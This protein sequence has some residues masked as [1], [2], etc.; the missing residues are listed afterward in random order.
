MAGHGVLPKQTKNALWCAFASLGP[1]NK[2]EVPK[3]QLQ[4]IC[5]NVSIAVQ[6]LHQDQQLKDYLPHR[7]A[8]T[9]DEFLR[10]VQ[11]YLV[12]MKD[13]ANVEL[14][15]QYCWRTFYHQKYLKASMQ[16]TRLGPSEEVTFRL[17]RIFNAISVDDT[18]S[19]YEGLCLQ[20][21]LLK[22]LHCT[23][24]DAQATLSRR[25]TFWHFLG[26]LVSAFPSRVDE[27]KLQVAVEDLHDEILFD[28]AKQGTLCK[29]GHMRHS[30]KER[31]FSLTPGILKYYTGRDKKNLKGVIYVNRRTKVE[32]VEGKEKHQNRMAITCGD[33]GTVYEIAAPTFE[34]I[35]SWMA[36][37]KFASHCDSRTVFEHA[38]IEKRKR[39]EQPLASDTSADRQLLRLAVDKYN[40]VSRKVSTRKLKKERKEVE[41]QLSANTCSEFTLCTWRISFNC[42]SLCASSV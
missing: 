4:T 7:D 22:Y 2:G 17:W 27:D 24:T 36:T 3:P 6:K 8:L 9:F 34:D 1:S 21:R 15:E 38:V 39:W 35:E 26:K 40:A 41:R 10:Y 16:W 42:I 37:I 5:A 11:S 18:I 29:K 28:I 33:T 19:P 20:E 14:I 23:V 25:Y 32:R 30:W 31:W 12:K 13:K